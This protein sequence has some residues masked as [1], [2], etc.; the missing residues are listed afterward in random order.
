MK[1]LRIMLINNLDHSEIPQ[2]THI[3][4]LGH[5]ILKYFPFAYYFIQNIVALY[6]N[7]LISHLNHFA[8]E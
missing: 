8:I 7:P 1:K 3:S 5:Y 4:F 6:F 2:K